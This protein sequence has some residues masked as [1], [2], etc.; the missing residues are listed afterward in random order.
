MWKTDGRGIG[1]RWEDNIKMGLQEIVWKGKKRI[2][3]P[4]DRA[5]GGLM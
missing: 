3:V 4:Q 1:C 2:D 5:G